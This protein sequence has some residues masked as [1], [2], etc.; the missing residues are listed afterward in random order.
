MLLDLSKEV[1]ISYASKY[2][3]P[4]LIIVACVVGYVWWTRQSEGFAAK[5]SELDAIH[6]T[7]IAQIENARTLEVKQYE[8]NI[9]AYEQKLALLNQQF[10]ETKLQ[11]D[12]KT[13]TLTKIY[14]KKYT[15]N[16]DPLAAK[17]SGLTGFEVYVP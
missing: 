12:Q 13:D 3:K 7:E 15:G 1:L 16:P 8:Q 10:E 6:K 14:T 4:A 2:W 9:K 11:L 17:L 5:L